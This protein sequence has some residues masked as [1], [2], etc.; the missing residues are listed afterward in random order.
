VTVAAWGVPAFRRRRGRALVGVTDAFVRASVVAFF[1][2]GADSTRAS[3][4]VICRA[5][6]EGSL[7]A[8]HLTVRLGNH[9][10]RCKPT[11]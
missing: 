2:A 11:R 8:L 10:V 5:S 4:D 9:R 3:R 1:M 7:F 6:G